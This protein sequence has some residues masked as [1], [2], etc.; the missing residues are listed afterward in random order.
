MV[1]I[2]CD[3]GKRAGTRALGRNL[4]PGRTVGVF[5]VEA[6]AW[7][8]LSAAQG[9]KYAIKVKDQLK[10]SSLF[11]GQVIKAQKLAYT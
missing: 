8:D 1:S 6:Y 3:A 2:G 4:H 9:N 10:Q 7:L 11:G 5:W